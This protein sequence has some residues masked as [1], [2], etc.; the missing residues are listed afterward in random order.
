MSEDRSESVYSNE[1]EMDLPDLREDSPEIE[2]EDD[3][4]TQHAGSEKL[5]PRPQ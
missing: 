5:P 4:K 3:I 1:S 2:H